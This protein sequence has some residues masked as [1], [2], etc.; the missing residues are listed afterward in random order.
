MTMP[1]PIPSI[2]VAL[3]AKQN[4]FALPS[5]SLEIGRPDGIDAVA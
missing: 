4:I 1:M 2:V 5:S 3:K